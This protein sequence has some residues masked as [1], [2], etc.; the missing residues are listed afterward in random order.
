M[1]AELTVIAILWRHAPKESAFVMKAR[2]GTGNTAEVII[3][4]SLNCRPVYTLH[5]RSLKT[6]VPSG[7]VLTVFHLPYAERVFTAKITGHLKNS[8]PENK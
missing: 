8:D 2:P 4:Q 5:W 1:N 7:N 3:M 6:D